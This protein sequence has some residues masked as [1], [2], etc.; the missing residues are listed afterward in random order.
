V[1]GFLLLGFLDVLPQITIALQTTFKTYLQHV[2]HGWYQV[3]GGMR[4]VKA[5]R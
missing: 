5:S 1:L 3:S 4:V 2:L